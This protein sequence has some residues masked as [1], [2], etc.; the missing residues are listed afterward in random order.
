MTISDQLNE[1]TLIEAANL[2]ALGSGSEETKFVPP[3]EFDILKERMSQ[4]YERSV[5]AYEKMLQSDIERMLQSDIKKLKRKNYKNLDQIAKS[6]SHKIQSPIG[7]IKSVKMQGCER[8]VEHKPNWKYMVEWL[9]TKDVDIACQ[10][11]SREEIGRWIKD[12]NVPSRYKFIDSHSVANPSL[13]ITDNQKKANFTARKNSAP[14]SKSALQDA[15]I[16]EIIRS[17]GYEPLT[18]P[19][20]LPG[21]PGVKSKIR[22]V[23]LK[24]SKLFTA[25]S[26]EHSWERLT[27]N[28]DIQFV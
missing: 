24:N 9:N 18:L 10:T 25:S 1:F 23:A 5:M 21:K 3:H 22:N 27:K 2:M 15:D 4:A 12:N 13:A 6:K 20:H 28:K 7:S 14:V 17:L 8:L 19:K 11:F 16:L 26:F